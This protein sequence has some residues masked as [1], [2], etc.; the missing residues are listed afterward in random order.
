MINRAQL[1]WHSLSRQTSKRTP[2]LPFSLISSKP[3]VK[4]L[5]RVGVFGFILGMASIDGL[6]PF[7]LSFMAANSLYRKD[8]ILPGVF[9]FL[10]T[11]LAMQSIISLRYLGAM[12]IFLLIFFLHKRFYGESELALGAMVVLS[13]L[14]AGI[15]FL[16]TR[17]VSLYDI[18]LL[19]VESAI[20]CIMTFIIPGGMPWI[21]KEQVNTTER[22]ICMA[23]LLGVV[24][25]IAKNIILLGINVRDV[26][27][28]L[29]V[30]ILA[31]IAGPGAGASAGIIIG[32]TGFSFS[33][34]PWSIAIMA[35]SGLVS[36]SFYKLG[37]VGTI[38]G[39]SMGY[40]LYNLHVNSMGEA[41]IPLPV[42]FVSYLLFL[43]LPPKVLK[44]VELY[45]ANSHNQELISSYNIEERARDRL[46]ELASLLNN[47]GEAFKDSSTQREERVLSAQYLDS[48]CKEAQI[49]ICSKCGMRRICWEKELKRTIS[50]FYTLIKNHEGISA[51]NTL[52]FLFKSRCNQTESIK[53]IVREQ[54]E[55]FNVKHH[56]DNIIRCNQELIRGHFS[57][58]AE[59][60][61]SLAQGKYEET[62]DR[63][64]EK[65]LMER[66]SEVGVPVERINIEYNNPEFN[67][68]IVKPPCKS[69]KECEIVIP[70]I[71]SDVLGRKTRTNIIDCPLKTGTHQCRLKIISEGILEVSVG[72]VGVAKQGQNISGDAFSF[73]QL[74]GGKYML[75]L[76]DGMGV[77]SEAA[78]HSEKTLTL[79]ERLLEA[80]YDPKTALTVANSAL[81]ATGEEEGFST[82]D[83]V[84]IDTNSGMA[85]FLKSGAPA[86]FIKRGKRI[87]VINGGNLPI[88]IM[89]E[90]PCN[91][92]EKSLRPGDMLVMV[93]DGVIDAFS[94]GQNGEELL[95]KIIM[96]CKTSNPQEMAEKIL[97]KTK[98]QKNPR[99]DMTILVANIWEKRFK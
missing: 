68:N 93:T 28:V 2:T 23:V 35:F 20:A 65:E 63:N 61:R 90:V 7:G 76:C 39:F 8:Y 54:S 82:I 98:E 1:K 6:Y 31:L 92:I 43:L 11:L 37:K 26:L 38:I 96:E 46:Y 59:M 33:L 84:L 18:F 58:A 25:S 67:V 89:D 19:L 45:F 81:I 75:A 15:L 51:K 36:G 78:K 55:I 73:M 9:S 87:I 24:L 27:G 91:I 77:G 70:I 86:C 32:I 85:K 56:I 22:N 53:A 79:L 12:G 44:K 72:V 14:I 13:N 42:L 29:S 5:M 80:G 50:A 49:K 95:R 60:I 94:E 30:L 21:F 34:S 17:G 16:T 66:F 88:G 74:K 10:G 41:I 52:P 83:L 69:D 99:D 4:E 48:V 3:V 40:L 64:S 97:N 62:Y 71:V 57:T 47:L